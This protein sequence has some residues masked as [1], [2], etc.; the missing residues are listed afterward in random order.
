M[1]ELS[2]MVEEADNLGILTNT[3]IFGFSCAPVNFA[4]GA[5]SVFSL[6]S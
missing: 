3:E 5:C 6:D 1:I 2:E 4:S